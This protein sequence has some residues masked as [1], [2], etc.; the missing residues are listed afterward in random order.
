MSAIVAGRPNRADRLAS[1]EGWSDLVRSA[2][3]WLGKAHCV[4]SMESWI[5]GGCAFA[6]M[7]EEDMKPSRVI[8]LDRTVCFEERPADC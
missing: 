5:V 8:S 7:L 2:V 6:M 4:D 3:V 1:F